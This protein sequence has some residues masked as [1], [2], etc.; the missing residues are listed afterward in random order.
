MKA[1]VLHGPEDL[2]YEDAPKPQLTPGAAILKVEAATICNA[3]DNKTYRSRPTDSVWPH[4]KPPLILGHEVCGHVVE[5]ADDVTRFDIGDRVGLWGGGTGGFA[6]YFL[7][8]PDELPAAVK[9]DPSIDSVTGSIMEMVG[10]T[11]RHL[12]TRDDQWLIKPDD[13]VVVFGL[14]PSGI[15]YV[16]EAKIMGATVIAVGKHD[17][18]MNKAIELGADEA[19]DYRDGDIAR[20]IKDKYGPADMVIDTTGKDILPESLTLLKCGGTFVPFGVGPYSV[21]EKQKRLAVNDITVTTGGND[22]RAIERGHEWIVEGRMKI[23]PLVTSHVALKDVSKGLDACMAK[24]KNL[25]K[26]AVDI[27]G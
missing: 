21:A 10:G 15:L 5:K 19:L 18:R 24:D 4:L 14:G 8:R 17:F 9:L 16:Q 2:R 27:L 1:A 26:I 11:M 12:V 20:R 6:E 7:I 23:K 3:T 25:L 13:L 22:Q